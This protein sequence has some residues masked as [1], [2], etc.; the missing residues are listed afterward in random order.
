MTRC[1]RQDGNSPGRWKWSK[2]S[3]KEAGGS[4]RGVEKKQ[5]EGGGE[6][7][8]ETREKAQGSVGKGS[9]DLWRKKIRESAKCG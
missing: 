6:M 7:V 5:E 9:K 4:R 1:G 3:E 2:T 8:K